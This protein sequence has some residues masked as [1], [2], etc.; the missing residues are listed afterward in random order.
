MERSC[1]YLSGFGYDPSTDDY[2]IVNVILSRR[3]HPKIECFSL[4]ANSWSCTKSK[5]PY[6]ENL[7]FGDGVFL[8]G[9]LHWL[10]KPKDKVAVIIAFDVT[11]RTLLEIPLP[12]DLAIM[13]KFNLFRFM[14]RQGCLVLCSF[15]WKN[16]RLM[17]EMWTMKEYKVQSSWIR[18]LVPY[19]NYY[20]LF[21]LF[22]PVCFIL[23]GE[24]L[25][26]NAINTLVRL[27]DKGELLE[28][29]MH[30][31]ILNKFYT[32]LHC[33]MYR[34]SLLSLPSAQGI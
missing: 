24:T 29:R 7:T 33:V 25:A 32:L 1:E 9:A 19:K 10:V 23:N 28:H 3:K 22:L 34:E 16:T 8:N 17:P 18:S 11:K 30:E 14:V 13:L 31:S 6:R 21:D 12:H 15:G 5:A 2:V 20:N 26:S 4:R 27:N